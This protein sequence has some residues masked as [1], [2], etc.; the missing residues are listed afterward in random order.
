MSTTT[1]DAK[2]FRASVLAERAT[3]IEETEQKAALTTFRGDLFTHLKAC[4]RDEELWEEMPRVLVPHVCN[5]EGKWGAGFVLAL[6]AYS[7]EAEDGYRAWFQRNR[8]HGSSGYPRLGN[9]QLVSL[10]WCDEG[11]EEEQTWGDGVYAANMIAQHKTGGVKP[12]RM[13]ALGACMHRLSKVWK[14]EI[15]GDF[16]IWC[17]KFGSGLAGGNWLDIEE[18]IKETWVEQFNFNVTVFKR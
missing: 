12:L 8:S 5:D 9:L 11:E 16:E 13:G 10:E 1:I 17:P 15:G 18:M 14:T 6:T 7:K 3:Q 4:E 2:A